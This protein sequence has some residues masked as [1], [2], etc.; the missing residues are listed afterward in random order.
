MVKFAKLFLLSAALC[1][2]GAYAQEKAFGTVDM[3]HHDQAAIVI[4]DLYMKLALN[5]KVYDSTGQLTNRYALQQGQKAL[6][7]SE[8]KS[9]QTGTEVN[10]IW[11]QGDGYAHAEE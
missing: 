3:I 11:I 1:C 10:V 4:G 7:E 2:S 5:L 6:Y 8:Y 9:A